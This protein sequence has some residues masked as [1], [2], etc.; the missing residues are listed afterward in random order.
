MITSCVS[1][2]STIEF[3]D[4]SFQDEVTLRHIKDLSF[5]IDSVT[6]N[7]I[8]SIK[9]FYGESKEKIYVLN[10]LINAIE[11]F[12]IDTEAWEDRIE[13]SVEGPQGVGEAS[14]LVPVSEDSLMVF[15][16]SQRLSIVNGKGEVIRRYQPCYDR[17]TGVGSFLLAMVQIS[18][19]KVRNRVFFIATNAYDPFERKSSRNNMGV[20]K[21]IASLDLITGECTYQYAYPESYKEATG[22]WAGHY[23]DVKYHDYNPL[24]EKFVISLPADEAIY[25]TDYNSIGERHYAGSKFFDKI[26][27]FYKQKTLE[28]IPRNK[29]KKDFAING[30]Y[31]NVRYD[32]YRDLYYR[33]AELPYNESGYESNAEAF[34]GIKEWTLIILD[35]NF[36]KVG[37][38]Q[39]PGVELLAGSFLITKDGLL[40]Y[41]YEKNK[42][43]ENHI[44]YALYEV[45]EANN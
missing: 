18:P 24:L 6:S 27:P 14:Y 41:Q 37:E 10:S 21:N 7:S 31:Q 4:T 5:P 15:S 38:V 36:K 8:R 34:S 12:D 30:S 25:L 32:T 22:L 39:M 23:Y 17:N 19:V 44:N 26:Q 40:I 1:D 3:E 45:Q 35:K 20:E 33:V 2:S 29:M 43:D 42:N 16:K 9:Y 28:T 13:L 11:I